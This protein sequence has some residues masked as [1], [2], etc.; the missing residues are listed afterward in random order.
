VLKAS[1][2]Q[3]LPVAEVWRVRGFDERIGEGEIKRRE[4]WYIMPACDLKIYIRS[5]AV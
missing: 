5:D 3:V 1:A 2:S 4:V